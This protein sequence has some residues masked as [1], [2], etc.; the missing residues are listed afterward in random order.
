M[1][2]LYQRA[3]V[4]NSSNCD[5]RDEDIWVTVSKEFDSSGTETK[6]SEPAETIYLSLQE[7]ELSTCWGKTTAKAFSQ[8]LSGLL[9][10]PCPLSIRPIMRVSSQYD[11]NRMQNVWWER[12]RLYSKRAGKPRQ[13]VPTEVGG[14]SVWVDSK[15]ASSVTPAY[16]IEKGRVDWFQTL[17]QDY[18]I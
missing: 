5:T 2:E 10:P 3:L 7:L 16:K 12:K 17:S 15:S 6:T 13:N 8:K 14:I 9:W 1:V 4:G 18:R 11:I